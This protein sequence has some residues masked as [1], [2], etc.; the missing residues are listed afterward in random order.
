[1][2]LQKY[3]RKGKK[4][5]FDEQFTIK[6]LSTIGNPLEKISNV[7]DFKIFRA[8]LELKLLNTEKKTMLEPNLLML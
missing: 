8:T 3:K 7:I 2:S 5:L 4:G 6:R 1:M